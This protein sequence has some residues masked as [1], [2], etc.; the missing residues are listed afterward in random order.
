MSNLSL[1]REEGSKE[2]LE[3]RGKKEEGREGEWSRSSED[4]TFGF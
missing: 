2:G 4:K 3:G 1:M